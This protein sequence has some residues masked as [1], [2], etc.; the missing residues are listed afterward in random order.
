MTRSAARSSPGVSAELEEPLPVAHQRPIAKFVH[1]A[2]RLDARWREQQ[3]DESG[4]GGARVPVGLRGVGIGDLSGGIRGRGDLF[5]GRV[6][7]HD[8][9]GRTE[10]KP[11][12]RPDRQ[13]AC[14]ARVGL[15]RENDPSVHPREREWD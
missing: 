13:A 11:G 3:V 9:A 6:D 2:P 5:D 1:L 15:E 14:G 4:T 7:H 12:L 10:R 8:V